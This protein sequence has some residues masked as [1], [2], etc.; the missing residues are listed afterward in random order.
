MKLIRIFSPLL[1]LSVL[2]V[3]V[4]AKEQAEEPE[5]FMPDAPVFAIDNART[6]EN[7]QQCYAA[8]YEPEIL[9]D[10]AVIVLPLV[11]ESGEAPDAVRVSLDLGSGR[12]PFVVKNYEQTVPRE[13]HTAE[14]GCVTE[15]Y[16]AE[17]WLALTGDRINGSYPVQMQVQGGE[18]Y[19]VY[20]TVTDGIDPDAKETEPVMTETQPPEEPPVLM[21][22]L[23]VQSV[24]GNAVQA[25]EETELHITLLNTSRAQA[26]ENLTVT[27]ELPPELISASASDTFFHEKIGAGASWEE[28]C[29]FTASADAPAGVYS[30]PLHFDYAYGKGMTGSGSAQVRV[31][32]TQPLEMEFPRVVLP[33]EAV[34]SDRLT[35]HIQAINLSRSAA[36]N[37]RA[38]LDCDGLLPE[39]TAFIG[40]V[41]GGTSAAVDLAVQVSTRRGAEPYGETSGMLTFRYTGID[42]TEHTAEQP[43]KILLKSPF[44]ERK[45]EPE[46]ASPRWWMGI[47]AAVGGGIL[48]LTVLLILRAKRRRSA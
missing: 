36:S 24:S 18:C 8:G 13:P 15:G 25:G 10:Y 21:P 11:C 7:M 3:P 16:L 19:T 42:G 43:V 26:L 22:K 14:D 12:I 37:V 47:M 39:G 27:A 41:A 2:T 44:S 45:T 23:L 34:V 32:V 38:E 48:L 4:S 17:F 31:T 40:D 6:Y 9:G 35:L 28:V 5:K 1:A 20:V 33:A 30:I 46:Q 29:T